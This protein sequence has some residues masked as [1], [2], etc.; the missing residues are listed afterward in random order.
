MAIHFIDNIEKEKNTSTEFYL[1]DIINSAFSFLESEVYKGAVPRYVS[2]AKRKEIENIIK[3]RYCLVYWCSSY[4][5]PVNSYHDDDG[6]YISSD[7]ETVF[8]GF[9]HAAAVK[10]LESDGIE[11][12]AKVLNAIPIVDEFINLYYGEGITF[13]YFFVEKK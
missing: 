13:S 1:R 11:D 3:E 6:D 7:S 9:D 8:Y 5:F 10:A 12:A 2:T 4:E